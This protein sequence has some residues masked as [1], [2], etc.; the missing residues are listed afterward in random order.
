MAT[1]ILPSPGTK[2]RY[3]EELGPCPE[4]CEHV[5]CALTRSMVDEP[6]VR[7]GEP[8]GYDTPFFREPHLLGDGESLFHARCLEAAV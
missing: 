6:C 5:D 7:C 4:A 2:D 1:A 3:G 8:I